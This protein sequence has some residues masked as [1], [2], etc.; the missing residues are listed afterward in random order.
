MR[1]GRN[2]PINIPNPPVVTVLTRFCD[3]LPRGSLW[4]TIYSMPTTEEMMRQ[5]Q[6]LRQ[7]ARARRKALPNKDELSEQI[8]RKLADLP[9]FAAAA[10][11]MF[12]VDS[13]SEVRTRHFFPFVRAAGKDIVVPFCSGDELELFR[14][15]DIEELTPGTLGILEPPPHL[16]DRP[17]RRVRADQLDLIVVPGLAFD[18]NLA[19]LGQG[20]GYYDRFLPRVGRE[21]TK[22]ALAFE[23]QI[24]SE[25]PMLPG[26]VYMDIIITEETVYKK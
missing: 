25:V 19:R 9:Q 11:I 24:F 7:I 22:A 3:P 20:K 23:C 4:H 1:N 14:L 15:Q 16:R 6:T 10:A 2:P 18:G 13:G 8:C 5:K 12:Y 21:I 26:D 17:E